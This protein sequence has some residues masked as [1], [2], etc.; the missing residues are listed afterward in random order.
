MLKIDYDNIVIGAIYRNKMSANL[1]IVILKYKEPKFGVASITTWCG[2][3]NH[4]CDYEI[5]DF[6]D[7]MRLIEVMSK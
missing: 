1:H 3:I 7:V 6:V 2:K 4:T 5:R